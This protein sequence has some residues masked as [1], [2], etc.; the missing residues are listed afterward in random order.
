MHYIPVIPMILV[1]GGVGIGTGWSVSISNHNP[2][3]IINMVRQAIVAETV[4]EPHPWYR[5][6]D[7]SI[8]KSG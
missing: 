1:N 6:F 3:D 5:G 8:S 7:G 2:I 4:T